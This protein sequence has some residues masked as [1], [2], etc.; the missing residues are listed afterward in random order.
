MFNLLRE[1]FVPRRRWPAAARAGPSGFRRLPSEECRGHFASGPHN[2]R[3]EAAAEVARLSG[4][5]GVCPLQL[6]AQLSGLP[7]QVRPLQ[8][9]SS[10]GRPDAPI[11]PF[12]H[13]EDIVPLE[14]ATCVAE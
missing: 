13:R 12:E 1:A 5:R 7:V 8:P 11:A 14:R 2:P 10:S 6:D 3:V 4:G 9:E